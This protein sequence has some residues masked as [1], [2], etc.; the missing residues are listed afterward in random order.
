MRFV[1]GVLLLAFLGALAVFAFQNDQT[2]NVRFLNYSRTTPVAL[3]AVVA[4]VL[5]MFTGWS[6]LGFVRAMFRR[7]ASDPRDDR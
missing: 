6:L 3:G 5:G 4:Y 7:V 2:V 1:W